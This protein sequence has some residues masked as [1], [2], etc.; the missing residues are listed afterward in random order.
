MKRKYPAGKKSGKYDKQ[1]REKK[2]KQTRGGYKLG[3][4]II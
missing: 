4:I 3:G 2:K 1:K